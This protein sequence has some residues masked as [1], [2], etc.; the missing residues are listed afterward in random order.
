MIC[1]SSHLTSTENCVSPGST[2]NEDAM[3]I[4]SNA[5][6][7]KSSAR[8]FRAFGRTQSPAT[9]HNDIEDKCYTAP[10]AKY[11]A[12]F[13][14]MSVLAGAIGWI[15]GPVIANYIIAR[16][17]TGNGLNTIRLL[18]TNL[19]V[20]FSILALGL[21]IANLSLPKFSIKVKVP[22]WT[23]IVS[24]AVLIIVWA[25]DRA[26]F[27]SEE[28]LITDYTSFA[29]LMAGL[30]GLI[31]FWIY[32]YLYE[33]P[34]RGLLTA[35]WLLLGAAMIWASCD[36]LFM[37]HERLA[38]LLTRLTHFKKLQD[39]ITLSYGA[40]GLLFLALFAKPLMK[41]FIKRGRIFYLLMPL[42]V[43]L[44]VGSQ[45]LDSFDNRIMKISDM[46]GIQPVIDLR[47]L[48]NTF[49]ETF[50]F[51][52]AAMFFASFVVAALEFNDHQLMRSLIAVLQRRS[53]SAVRVR[54]E[55]WGRTWAVASGIFAFVMI[56]AGVQAYSLST[57]YIIGRVADGRQIRVFADRF[58]TPDGLAYHSKYGL[59]IADDKGHQV[60]GIS[61]AG[62]LRVWL[63]ESK[64]LY[65]PESLA[66]GPDD[67]LYVSDDHNIKVFRVDSATGKVTVVADEKDGLQSPEGIAFAPDGALY[68][69][70]QKTSAIYKITSDHKISVFADWRSGLQE[71][72]EL[73]FDNEGDLYVTDDGAGK[74]FKFTPD[75]RGQVFADSRSGLKTPESIAIAR[76][77]DIYISDSQARKIFRFKPDGSVSLFAEF[78]LEVDDL[79]GIAFDD[80]GNLFVSGPP[81]R[82]YKIFAR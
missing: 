79:Q 78:G 56:L 67:N 42:S 33:G 50:E 4:S 14:I 43:C 28:S 53:T 77:G 13:A 24:S 16:T 20:T 36:D 63:D 52:A 72:E 6:S 27:L 15:A 19:I 17:A 75:G 51:L 29:L 66:W 30:V 41:E 37:V 82:V 8:C 35:F 10:I 60:I 2:S 12:I 22:L 80:K 46:L 5:D 23:V 76:D 64:G 11:L 57:P 74:V 26:D 69:G 65:S 21:L 34:R 61:P 40:G 71:P 1:D 73:A 45:V 47:V 25:F 68:L 55:S 58:N 9:G 32:R 38:A 49:E 3:P 7:D 18:H 62:S 81:N 59:C 48:L 44:F 39:L 31:N 70:D 54:F